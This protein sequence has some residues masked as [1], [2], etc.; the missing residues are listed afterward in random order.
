MTGPK[1]SIMFALA[2]AVLAVGANSAHAAFSVTTSTYSQNFDDL[3]SAG[4]STG[5]LDGPGGTTWSVGTGTGVLTSPTQTVTVSTGTG[6]A[7]ANYNFGVAG[8]NPLAD[9]A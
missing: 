2:A 7:G 8:T 3:G 5:A 1:K 9:R 6:T 4:T